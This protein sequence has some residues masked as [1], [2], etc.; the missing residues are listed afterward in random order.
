MEINKGVYNLLMHE[1]G[2]EPKSH[3]VPTYN[4]KLPTNFNAIYTKDDIDYDI[5]DYDEYFVENVLNEQY[6][7]SNY[8]IDN[9][10]ILDSKYRP[11]FLYVKNYK[12]FIAR[13]QISYPSAA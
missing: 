4:I 6:L 10:P 12:L 1:V 13:Q 7:T 11:V 2:L 5:S 3:I 8:P 9:Y